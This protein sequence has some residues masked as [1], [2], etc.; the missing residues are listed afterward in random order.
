[1]RKIEFWLFALC[2]ICLSF[3]ATKAIASKEA[4]FSPSSLSTGCDTA[5]SLFW[6]GKFASQKEDAYR[7][8]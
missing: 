2:L 4:R 6:K 8:Y 3:L 1:M 5:P 7:Y